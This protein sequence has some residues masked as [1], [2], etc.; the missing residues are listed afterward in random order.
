MA[1]L[2]HTIC[3]R[4]RCVPLSRL[5]GRTQLVD[6]DT[7][8]VAIDV[9]NLRDKDVRSEASTCHFEC[10]H[11]QKLIRLEKYVPLIVGRG[12]DADFIVKNEYDLSRQHFS[13]LWNDDVLILTDMSR[14]GTYVNGTIVKSRSCMLFDSDLVGFTNEDVSFT[15]KSETK[16]MVTD[17]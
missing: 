5:R 13:L 3:K 9:Q 16:F 4:P 2:T 10:F 14:N 1:G 11:G 7:R 17:Q 15:I 6:G 8:A 12:D